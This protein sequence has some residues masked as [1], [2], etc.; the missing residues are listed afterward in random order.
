MG[1]ALKKKKKKEEKERN[2]GEGWQSLDSED[3]FAKIKA[4]NQFPGEEKLLV[5]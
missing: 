2:L 5:I 4:S 1:V 3:H